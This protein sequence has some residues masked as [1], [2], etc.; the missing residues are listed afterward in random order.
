MQLLKEITQ[1]YNK[2]GK[3]DEDIASEYDKT[4]PELV[5]LIPELTTEY[6]FKHNDNIITINEIF[7]ISNKKFKY[8]T[9]VNELLNYINENV[10]KNLLN[11]KYNYVATGAGKPHTQLWFL[12]TMMRN[13]DKADNSSNAEKDASIFKIVTTELATCI[14][15]HPDYSR[16]NVCIIH[17]LG[18]DFI[19]IEDGK[20]GRKVFI[21]CITSDNVKKCIQEK[22]IKSQRSNKSLIILTGKRLRLGISF[23][24]VDIAIHCPPVAKVC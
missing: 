15:N 13:T 7:E 16:F 6:T 1:E 14:L 24:C 22:E 17:G 18:I 11:K 23:P 5:Y 20:D 10:Y 12:P 8:E 4:Y 19:S 9:V 2:Y 21:D 3:T